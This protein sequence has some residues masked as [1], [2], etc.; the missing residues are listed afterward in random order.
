M[1]KT[2]SSPDQYRIGF[3]AS[4]RGNCIKGGDTQF[5]GFHIDIY[6]KYFYIYIDGEI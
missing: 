6:L 1:K 3:P 4:A 2:V 5:V